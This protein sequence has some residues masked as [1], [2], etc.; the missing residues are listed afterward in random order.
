[1]SDT[2]TAPALHVPLLQPVGVE[3]CPICAAATAAR[4]SAHRLGSTVS[5]RAADETIR[6]HPH[7]RSTD[8]RVTE[9]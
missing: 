6:Q 5:E 2:A 7:R 9:R 8:R 3:G 4:A 1:M